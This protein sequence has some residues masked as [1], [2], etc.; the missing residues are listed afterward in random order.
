[1]IHQ[2]QLPGV[3]SRTV[4]VKPH[5]IRMPGMRLTAGLSANQPVTPKKEQTLPTALKNR[6][7]QNLAGGEWIANTS[8]LE[9]CKKNW[10]F[11]I[12]GGASF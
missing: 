4:L 12:Y 7:P 6:S 3:L 1:M 9:K 10:A 5:P 2:Y 8:L 11:N